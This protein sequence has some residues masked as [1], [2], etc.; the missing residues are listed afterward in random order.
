MRETS[1]ATETSPA[2]TVATL[3]H[4][5]EALTDALQEATL[6]AR[7]LL[8]ADDTGW[9]TLPG[10]D[11]DVISREAILITARVARVMVVADPLIKRG[12]SIRVAY[13]GVPSISADAGG[14]DG[15]QDVNA[16]VQAFLDD[17]GNAETLTSAQACEERERE[18]A[19]D[20]NTFH[21]LITSPR[22]GRVQVRRI[23][24]EQISD[25]ITDPEDATTRWYYLRSWTQRV[26][27]QGYTGLTRS[28]TETRRAYYPDVGHR[29]TQRPRTIDGIPVEWDKPVV[30][31]EVNRPSGARW[32]VPDVLAAIPW[33]R[34]YKSALEDWAKHHKALAAIAYT[35]SVKG[36][37]GAAAVRERM[38]VSNGEAGQTAIVGEGNSLAAVSKSGAVLQ[39]DAA[40][41]LAGLVAAALDV[42]KTM[43]LADPGVTGARATAETLDRPL[44]LDRLA[45]R[46]LDTDLLVAVLEH[47]VREAV[48][49]PGGPLRGS[50]I[51]DPD[52]GREVV[53]LTGGQEPGIVVDWPDLSKTDP[54]SLMETLSTA[55]GMDVVPAEVLARLVLLALGVDDVDEVIDSMRDDQGQFVPPSASTALAGQD[56]GY[57]GAG[58]DPGDPPT[59]DPPQDQQE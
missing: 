28:R 29:P 45:R 1:T 46:R 49:A 51:R 16:L 15:G 12:V 35:A 50:I 19:T 17:P 18:R 43:L 11:G 30:H 20:G 33:A 3:E 25:V 58:R 13:L 7:Q 6:D 59:Q 38:P 27:E 2:G 57:D 5:V 34:G 52:T 10:Q 40:E 14:E 4:Q 23:P 31:T 26:V 36:R 54:V 47:V 21:T 42:P 41:P 56:P 24:L 32:G 48:R 9:S 22:T 37:K 44:E 39:A 55:D 53:T 8:A